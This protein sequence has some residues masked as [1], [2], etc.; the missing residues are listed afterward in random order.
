MT[1]VKA[2]TI[3]GTQDIARFFKVMN[4]I[5]T[6]ISKDEELMKIHHE[7]KKD[8][9]YYQKESLMLAQDIYWCS[10]LY[11]EKLKVKAKPR[12]KKK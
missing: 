7:L 3:P 8:S 10:R 1:H 6:I 4:T 9:K 11:L 12:A 5:Y 2:K